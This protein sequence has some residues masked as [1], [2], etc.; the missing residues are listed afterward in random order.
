MGEPDFGFIA[1]ELLSAQE[2][3]GENVPNLVITENPERLEASYA[4]LIPVLVKSIQELQ[5]S[6]DTVKT[7]LNRLKRRK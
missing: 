4:K 6:L 2:K 7:E 3:V 1:Q 5:E